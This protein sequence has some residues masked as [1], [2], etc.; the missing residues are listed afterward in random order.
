MTGIEITVEGGST[1]VGLFAF[2]L[3][4]ATIVVGVWI[5][6]VAYRGYRRSGERSVLFLAVGIALA[7]TVRTSASIV[8]S[9]AG[10]S[11]VVTNAV[12]VS[13]QF[14]GLVL[15]LYAIYGRPERHGG[16]AVAA[17]VLGGLLTL[18]VP[19]VVI[20]TFGPN[21]SLVEAG[22]NGLP[23]IVGA[24]VTIQAYR[25]YRRYGQRPMLLLAVGLGLLTVGSFGT[26]TGLYVLTTVSDAGALVVI[27]SVE[28]GGLLAI[29]RSL[30]RE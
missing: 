25:G 30:T 28:L 6:L 18:I 27:G 12:A 7:S 15:I 2:G 13:S 24:F 23:A 22:L 11:S 4:F 29:L 19:F 9:T 16:R 20:D 8:F 14:A 17:A 21:E 5:A 26:I 10:A 3:A 1:A